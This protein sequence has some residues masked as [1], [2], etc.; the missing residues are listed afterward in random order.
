MTSQ[1]QI[2]FV[3]FIALVFPMLQD[4]ACLRNIVR[5]LATCYIDILLRIQRSVVCHDNLLGTLS[6]LSVIVTWASLCPKSCILRQ[7]HQLNIEFVSTIYLYTIVYV[8]YF[9]K[10]KILCGQNIEWK[11]CS[12]SNVTDEFHWKYTKW[13]V[14]PSHSYHW[15]LYGH[16]VISLC[17]LSKS[18]INVSNYNGLTRTSTKR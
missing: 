9:D 11:C 10:L 14:E 16:H 3:V 17:P 2:L 12:S 8:N 15:R 1:W 18:P 13:Y 4:R 6:D 7:K 5:K